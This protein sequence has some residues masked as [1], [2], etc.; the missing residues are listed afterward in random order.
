MTKLERRA[1][2]GRERVEEGVQ[3]RQILFQVRR[4][5]KQECA[6]LRPEDRRRFKKLTHAVPA[7]AQARV[8]SNSL[9]RLERQLEAF[10]RGAVPAVNDLLSRC[11]VERVVDLDGGKSLRIVR[12]HLRRRQ[13]RRIEAALPF[14]IVV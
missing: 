3:Q 14:G 11:A 5:L 4:Q 10:G 6:E 2:P 1:Y 12:E 8:V 13:C 7:V 9:G